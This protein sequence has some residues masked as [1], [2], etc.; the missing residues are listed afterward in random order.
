[1][2]GKNHQRGQNFI[3]IKIFTQVYMGGAFLLKY[4]VLHINIRM[5]VGILAV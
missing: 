4:Q 3:K 2:K 5:K 1:M